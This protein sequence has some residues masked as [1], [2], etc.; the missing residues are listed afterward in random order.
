VATLV[1]LS[2]ATAAA[3]APVQVTTN[4]ALYPSFNPAVSDYVVRC[5]S[6]TPVSVTVT[7]PAGVA[8]SVDGQSTHTTSFGT[9]VNVSS[10][11]SFSF[12]TLNLDGT[13]SATYF[14]RCLPSDFPNFTS[15]RLG[16]PQAAFYVV[17]PSGPA[18]LGPNPPPQYLA[19]FDANGVPVWWRQEPAGSDAIM[20]P[21]GD[22]ASVLS[23]VNP[24]IQEHRLDGSL[25]VGL[26]GVN[27]L[28]VDGHELQL[29]PNGNYLTAEVTTVPGVNLT[30][31]GGPANA[32]VN[33]QVIEELTPGGSLVWSWDT[34]THISVAETDP[35]FYADILNPNSP[36]GPGFDMYHFNSAT[37][38][39]NYVLLSYR[40][41]DAV[42]LINKTTGNIVWKLGGSKTPQSLRISGDPDFNGPGTGFGGQHFARFYG[43]SV[44]SIT[45]HDD[46]TYR[47]RPPRAVRYAISG[48]KATLVESLSDPLATSSFCCGSATKL[49]GGDWVASWGFTPIVTELSPQGVRQ[50]LL[51]W[52]DPGFFSYRVEPVLPGVTSITALRTGM[53]AQFPR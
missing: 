1:G 35:T 34:A 39:G 47:N 36:F 41:L 42:Y 37:E 31:M 40:H 9:S 53:N 26:N 28:H 19:I 2:A 8:V 12:T 30:F 44:N 22:V 29:L 13:G 5:Q 15:Q 32:T 27:G 45:I 17:K 6:G 38:L 51:Q 46:G 23:H 43:G 52:T 24:Q 18:S 50:F 16:T 7:V 49:P 33:D 25:A 20:F 21:N 14:V 48:G 10:G 3:V 4:P 11:Q